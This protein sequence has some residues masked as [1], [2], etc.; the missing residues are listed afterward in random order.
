LRELSLDD[1]KLALAECA[2]LTGDTEFVVVGSLAI[3]GTYPSAPAVLRVSQDIDLF[4]RNNVTLEKNRA[5]Y[6]SLWPR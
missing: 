4:S 6:E 1:L 5:I 2:T 3:L